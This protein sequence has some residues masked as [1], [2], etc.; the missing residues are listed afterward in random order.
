MKRFFAMITALSL[1]IVTLGGCSFS[2]I[3]SAK[4]ADLSDVVFEA[5]NYNNYGDLYISG[6]NYLYTHYGF[7][8]NYLCLNRAGVRYKLFGDRDLENAYYSSPCYGVGNDIY[9][10]VYSEDEN[11]LS[12]TIYRYRLADQTLEPLVS[13]ESIYSW[14]PMEDYLIYLK[15]F[16]AYGGLSSLYC[17]DLTTKTE[18]LIA[19]EVQEFF[20]VDD[21]IHYVV[22]DGGAAFY[23]YDTSTDISYPHGVFTG[24]S[25]ME[26]TGYY[27]TADKVLMLP[28]TTNEYTAE[29]Q[30]SVYDM[31]TETAA[32]YT[33]PAQIYSL[34]PG[35]NYAYALTYTETDEVDDPLFRLENTD[36]VYQIDLTTGASTKLEI[37]VEDTMDIYVDA[38][39]QL[40]LC[41]YGTL[42]D[43]T[44]VSK[45]DPITQTTE[46]LFTY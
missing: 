37:E 31:I 26:S 9:F 25:Q 43:R 16:D 23:I 5:A 33:L 14:L 4:D 12:T 30:F 45:F 46:E 36:A 35:K 44:T 3:R 24:Y 42:S 22:Y 19:K 38:E 29:A 15:D 10:P 32:T 18:Q 28:T 6:E 20:V 1:L 2:R 8:D 17:Y 7:F 34:I 27:F 39:D 40:Y 21:Q 41:S 11:D 13:H